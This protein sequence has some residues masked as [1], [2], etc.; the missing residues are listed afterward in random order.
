MDKAKITELA[1]A[2]RSAREAL[3]KAA[4][5]RLALA[6]PSSLEERKLM[7]TLLAGKIGEKAEFLRMEALAEAETVLAQLVAIDPQDPNSLIALSSHHHYFTNDRRRALES[8]VDAVRAAD[9]IGSYVRCA[10]SHLIR[11]AAKQANFDVVASAIQRLIAYRP[12]PD[13]TDEALEPDI[14]SRIPHGAV[15]DAL[16]DGYKAL[17]QSK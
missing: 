10:N 11:V 13:S 17:L 15:P 4:A 16:I 3:E 7:L 6:S 12:G 2:S 14:L 1:E 9:K 5:I 8:A